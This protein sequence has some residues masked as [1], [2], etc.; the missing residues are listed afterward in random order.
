MSRRILVAIAVVWF[1]QNASA[2]DSS[3]VKPKTSALAGMV[4]TAVG[5]ALKDATISVDNTEFK[6]V[7]ND[8]GLFFLPA[9]PAGKNNFTVLRLG[10]APVHFQIDLAPDS[11][12]VVNIPMKLVQTL[13]T[14][15]VEGERI[16]AKLMRTGFYE[17][18]KLG[19]GSFIGEDKIEK[20]HYATQPSTFL[21]D[22][23]GF[24]VRCRS[25][26]AC[27]V[28]TNS[29]CRPTV[30]VNG[31]KRTGQFDEVVDASEIFAIE[32]YERQVLVPGEFMPASCVIAVWTKGWADMPDRPETK[33]P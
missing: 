15:A 14:V 6:A 17:R 26:G 11:T 27:V 19:L 32:T 9:I 10:Y 18:R 30:Y 12:L 21:R 8:S 22:V 33:K 25:V 16:S 3:N 13:P 23:R 29:G 1:A 5:L 4:R 2:Q 24:Q 20:L 28:S 31:S 7:T